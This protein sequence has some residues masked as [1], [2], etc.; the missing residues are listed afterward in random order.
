MTTQDMLD[1]RY[2]RRRSPRRR[3][4][5]GIA[6]ALVATGV[7]LYGWYTFSNALDDVSAQPTGFRVEDARTVTVDF[8]VTI[9]QG[10][11]AACVLEA[12]DEEHS[13]VGWRVVE[14][15]ASDQHTRAFTETIPTVALATTGLVNSC[16]VT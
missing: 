2:G 4:M 12:Q 5:A 7:G 15:E 1:E 6:L 9:P 14:F 13:V 11:A 8:Q 16:W 10:R 3:W